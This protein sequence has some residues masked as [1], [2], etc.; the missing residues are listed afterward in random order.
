MKKAINVL[1]NFEKIDTE[2]K[3][4]WLGF[5]YADGSVSSKENKIELGLA[6]KDYKQIEKFRT[7]MNINN[8]ISYRKATKA[9]RMSFRSDKCKAD[10]INKG[11]VPRKSLILKFPT[12]EQVP[13]EL[14]RHFIR[15]Y[16]DGD[17]WFSNTPSC[18]QVGIIGTEDFIKG[19]LNYVE[20][21]NTENTI[22]KVNR[23]NG[24]KRYVFGAYQ[25]VYNFLNWLYKDANIYLDRK[26]EHYLDFINNGSQY[27]QT[28]KFAV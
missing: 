17:G 13:R 10:L 22:F 15:G 6:E 1:N 28:K 2:E 9:Y 3:A 4:Y 25:D 24:A 12:E 21:I 19:F 8:K 27:H 14:I 5:L 26:Y 11:C 23:E 16:F 18:F 7:F 20:N